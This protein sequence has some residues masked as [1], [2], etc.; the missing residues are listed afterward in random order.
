MF[1]IGT[2][3]LLIIAVVILL[4]VGPK[5]LPTFLRTVGKYV[6]ALKRQ[7]NEFRQ[8][9]DEALK[10]TELDQLRKDVAAMKTDVESSIRGATKS[11]EDDVADADRAIKAAGKPAG[12]DPLAK[13]SDARKPDEASAAAEPS[14]PEPLPQPAGQGAKAPQHGSS[15]SPAP[16]GGGRQA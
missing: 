1:D 8:H 12:R 4:V 7:A 10:E 11:L 6:G 9:F 3:E 14:A 13:S 2:Y 16:V 5:D 15:E